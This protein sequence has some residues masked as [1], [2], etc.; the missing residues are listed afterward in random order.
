MGK[1]HVSQHEGRVIEYHFSHGWMGGRVTRLL[2][3]VGPATAKLMVSS[4]L[5]IG[6]PLSRTGVKKQQEAN[7]F[8]R[9]YT[10]FFESLAN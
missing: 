4:S 2:K 8:N 5:A 1:T 9:F 10:L 7:V 6:P 3:V